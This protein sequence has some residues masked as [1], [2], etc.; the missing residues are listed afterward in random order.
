M[1]S[2]LVAADIIQQ[3]F[4]HGCRESLIGRLAPVPR[5]AQDAHFV[6][7]LHHDDR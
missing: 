4:G 6:L 5:V 2:V 3:L 7:H 1:Q